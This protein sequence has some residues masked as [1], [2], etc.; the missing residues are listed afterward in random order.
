MNVLPPEFTKD[1]F[2]FVQVKRNGKAAMYARQNPDGSTV[3]FEVFA[4]KSKNNNEIYPGQHAFGVWAWAPLTQGRADIYFDR[5]TSEET[6]IPDVDPET[7]EVN[8]GPNV[9]LD[10]MPDVNEDP[11]LPHPVPPLLPLTSNVSISTEPESVPDGWDRIEA[12]TDQTPVEVADPVTPPTV[13]ATPDGGAVV[14]VVKVR[15]GR[16]A[17][18][19]TFPVGE[20]T[21]VQF[22]E[23]N[24]MQEGNAYVRLMKEIE[25]GKVK[26]VRS[27]KLTAGRGRPTAIYATV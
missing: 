7:G 12:G 14:E 11:T 13:Q 9:A 10:D 4:L 21:K 16:V 8:S 22:A 27:E 2:K 1:N 24:G 18:A 23:H 25:A 26:L 5:I 17:A 20:F 6:V 3:N 19:I 15:K